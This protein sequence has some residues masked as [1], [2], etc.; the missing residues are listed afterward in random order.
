[1]LFPT[2][3]VD[4]FFEYPNEII[5]ISQQLQFNRTNAVPGYRSI[6][7]HEF[8]YDFYNHVNMKII[9]AL[10]PNQINDVE[11]SALTTFQLTE[12]NPYDGWVH[13]DDGETILTAIVYL[14]DSTAGTSIYHKKNPYWTY[15]RCNGRD[16]N[17]GKYD[18]FGNYENY[19]DSD[20]SVVKDSKNL[21]NESFEET[22]SFKGRF[23]RMV[24]FDARQYHAAQVDTGS[25]N[26]LI[27]ISFIKEIKLHSS[28]L[29][30]H[31]PTIHSI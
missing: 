6:P 21:N 9:A 13:K 10:Y 7:V 12:P 15:G 29:Y 2:L 22:I 31:V 20:L 19:A 11:F 27:L 4:D 18:Y 28:A 25:D 24:C 23:N 5:K 26:R 3:C 16:S 30:Y 1:M 14:S 17:L 8:S